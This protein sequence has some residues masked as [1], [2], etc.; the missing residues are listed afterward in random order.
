MTWRDV[1]FYVGRS[2]GE[3]DCGCPAETSLKAGTGVRGLALLG[4]RRKAVWGPRIVLRVGKV[5]RDAVLFEPV[6]ALLT[7][8]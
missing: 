8:R 3:P 2:I 1:I 4:H 7:W 5:L 6:G